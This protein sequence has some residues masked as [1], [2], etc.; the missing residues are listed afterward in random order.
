M[1]FPFF[2]HQSSHKHTYTTTAGIHLCGCLCVCNILSLGLYFIFLADL[3]WRLDGDCTSIHAPLNLFV[4]LNCVVLICLLSLGLILVSDDCGDVPSLALTPWGAT[5][6]S[7]ASS[8]W[9]WWVSLS[10]TRE[11]GIII[12][13]VIPNYIYLF[14]EN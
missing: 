1:Y 7:V 8:T 5:E 14:L 2:F 11:W 6:F 13:L 12:M 4:G 3:W 9:G 10:I